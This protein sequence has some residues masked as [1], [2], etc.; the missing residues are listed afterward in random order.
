MSSFSE[1]IKTTSRKPEGEE[2][3]YNYK[4]SRT[5]VQKEAQEKNMVSIRS[6]EK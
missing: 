1:D 4:R 6:V 5:W 2:E 3:V